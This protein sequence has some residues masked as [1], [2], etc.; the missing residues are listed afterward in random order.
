[1]E[2]MHMAVFQNWLKSELDRTGI[3]QTELGRELGIGPS[4]VNKIISGGRGLKLDE[5]VKCI[6]IFK[7]P[8]ELLPVPIAAI[9]RAEEN[10]SNR[11]YSRENYEPRQRGAIP[12][13]DVYAGAGEG[14]VGEVVQIKRGGE[15]YSGHKVVAEWN[16]PDGYLQNFIKVSPRGSI[17]VEVR[18]D[19]MDPTLRHGDKVIVDL[20]VNELGEDG[21]YLISDGH[22]AP[23]VKRL[24]YIFKSDPPSAKI[25]SDNPAHRETQFMELDELHV[26]GRIAGRITAQ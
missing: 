7:T 20:T 12:E 2:F 10:D 14:A 23:R 19:S 16:F 25:I 9:S 5:Y 24:E 3:N 1:M 8:I 15:S 22:S 18:G 13:L 6:E 17:V 26:L 21:L 4:G 11:G